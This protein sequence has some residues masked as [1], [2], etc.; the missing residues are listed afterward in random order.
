MTH[1]RFKKG[2]ELAAGDKYEMLIEEEMY[3]LIIKGAK[4]ADLGD[5][6]ISAS[7]TS[8]TI[9]SE[10]VSLTITGKF[11]IKLKYRQITHIS[12]NTCKTLWCN[13]TGHLWNQWPETVYR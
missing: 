12:I 4:E 9:T 2:K 7:N 6:S 11:K 5:Y 8:G 10:S 13:K 3:I 1:I